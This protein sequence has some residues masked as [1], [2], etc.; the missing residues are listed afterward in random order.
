MPSYLP[1]TQDL[2]FCVRG[3][4]R[5]IEGLHHFAQWR[6]V[7]EV[8]LFWLWVLFFLY[9]A[10]LRALLFCTFSS[11]WWCSLTVSLSSG[12]VTRR[13]VSPLVSGTRTSLG[14]HDEPTPRDNV[15]DTEEYHSF[16]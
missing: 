7:R 15:L 16:A 10:Y 2:R 9:H 1:A 3:H 11:L 13:T 8:C 14:G 6:V 4:E 12:V 5:L